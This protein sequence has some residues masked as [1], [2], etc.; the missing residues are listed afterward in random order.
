MSVIGFLL[1]ALV[2]YQ[3]PNRSTIIRSFSLYVG[4]DMRDRGASNLNKKKV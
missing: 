4:V 1:L 3:N 2:R